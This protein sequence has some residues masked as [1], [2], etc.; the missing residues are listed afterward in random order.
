MYVSINQLILDKRVLIIDGIR[1]DI[2]S[3]GK[4]ATETITRYLSPRCTVEIF[5][6][7]QDQVRISRKFFVIKSFPAVILIILNKYCR[8]RWLEFFSRF[9]PWLLFLL[10]FKYYSFRP[11]IMIF[12]HHCTFIFSKFFF[13]NKILIWH[14]VPNLKFI[15]LN[16]RKSKDRI[17]CI[18]FERFF[19]KGVSQSWVLSFTEHKFIKRFYK[20]KS[21]IFSAID[22]EPNF[23]K[24]KIINNAWLLVGNWN[25]T[26][27]CN[28]A[29]NFFLSYLQLGN[30]VNFDFNSKFTIAGTGASSFLEKL[31]QLNHNFQAINIQAL[32]SYGSLS[33]FNHSALL[34]PIN[35][36]AG[37][38]LKTLEA[39]SCDMPVVGTAQAFS[40]LPSKIWKLGGIK[41]K[42][43]YE[44]AK[45][46]LNWKYTHIVI[47]DLFPARAYAE[48]QKNFDY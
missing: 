45:F 26:E 41:F 30:T 17:I 46:C 16:I 48:Y 8:S 4:T 32:D 28:G 33:E 35:E 14:D 27:N 42:S 6:M 44:M 1:S 12:N 31:I 18:I 37:I 13:I 3:G 39:W 38:K 9:S 20:T 29:T 15:N 11:D 24:A 36:G 34:A 22:Y 40:G 2:P 23:R 19:L 7:S 10:I 43:P 5:K 47:E 25:R 21:L